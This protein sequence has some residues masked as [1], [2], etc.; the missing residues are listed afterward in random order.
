MNIVCFQHYLTALGAIISVPFILSPYFCV[1]EDSVGLS[2]LI[3]T[4]FFVSGVVTL[5]QSTVGIR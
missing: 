1:D 2:E 5:L 3:G 4:I